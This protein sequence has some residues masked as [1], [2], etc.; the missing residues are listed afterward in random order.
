M[1][2]LLQQEF[3]FFVFPRALWIITAGISDYHSS[4]IPVFRTAVL[5]LIRRSRSILFATS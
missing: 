4:Y 3:P 5:D 1:L 2:A